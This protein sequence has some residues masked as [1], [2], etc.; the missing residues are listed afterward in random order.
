[1]TREEM[2]DAL[3][4]LKF[5]LIWPGRWEDVGFTE[6]EIW[7]NGLGYGYIM[8]DEPTQHWEG[9][10]L[11]K[12]KWPRIKEK[13]LN[14][15]LTYEDIAG[16]TI[17]DC[18][19]TINY[20]YEYYDDQEKLLA[21]LYELALTDY[22]EGCFYAMAT[23]DGIKFFGV[24]EEFKKFFEREWADKYW[25]EMSDDL[26]A[27]WIDRLRIQDE[28]SDTEYAKELSLSYSKDS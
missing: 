6:R 11:G 9:P 3:G 22:P 16:T 23:I 1:M 19:D 4:K 12:D 8:Y 14:K 5:A 10:G 2:L 26:L 15:T 18:L 7:I 28:P 24:E 25:E 21:D 27:E 13:I 17:A 20:G